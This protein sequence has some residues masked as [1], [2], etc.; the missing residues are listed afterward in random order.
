ML[1]KS[2][3]ELLK[4]Q[5]QAMVSSSIS[6]KGYLLLVNGRGYCPFE[7][8]SSSLKI[9]KDKDLIV[10]WTLSKFLRMSCI[11]L[12]VNCLHGTSIY[13]LSGFCEVFNSFY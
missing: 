11:G 9:V 12:L 1:K 5:L 3:K 4:P 2:L 13:S 8:A 10:R 7:T 6:R